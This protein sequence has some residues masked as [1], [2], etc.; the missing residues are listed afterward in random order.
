M[1]S[2]SEEDPF[3]S[4]KGSIL[5]EPPLH[6]FVDTRKIFQILPNEILD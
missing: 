1:T 2:Q 4:A 5:L 3:Y 6:A